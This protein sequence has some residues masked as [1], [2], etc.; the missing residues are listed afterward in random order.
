MSASVIGLIAA[1]YGFAGVA[2]GA[3][4]A[5]A[6]KARLDDY[7]RGIWDTA[8]L[9]LLVHAVALLAVSVLMQR[10]ES[11]LL[12][13]AAAAF[14]GGMLLFSGSLYALALSGLRALGAV[15]P[16]GGLGLLAG[17]ALLAL[18]ALRAG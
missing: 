18:W 7:A 1:V 4:G 15:T 12:L 3:F 6:L 11:R 2:L 10:A 8:T 5:H 9:Y 16:F 14:A 17:W 13:A